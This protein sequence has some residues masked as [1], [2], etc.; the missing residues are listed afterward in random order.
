MS[1][2]TARTLGWTEMGLVPDSVI[3]AGIR[4][5]LDRKAEEIQS[6]DVEFS[7]NTLND[8]V[9]MMN[10]SPIAL[11]PELANEQH[12]EVPATFFGYCMGNYRKYSCCEWRDDTRTLTDAEGLALKTT[13]ERAGIENGMRILDMGCGWGSVSLYVAEHFPESQV[14]GVSNSSSQR[15]YILSQARE[16]GLDNLEIITADMNDF[17]APG[18]FD[19]IVSVEMF[20]HMRNYGELFRRISTWLNDGGRFFMHI[21]THRT[22]PYEFIDNGPTDWMSR[23]FFSGGIMPSVDLPLRFPKHLSVEQRWSWNGDHYAKT[24]R[25][26]LDTMDSNRNHIMPILRETYGDDEADRWWMRWRMFYMACEE[27]FAYDNGNEW[28]V[29]H[30][31]FSKEGSETS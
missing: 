7:S 18:T 12:Y 1:V 19:R 4:R 8:F 21:F 5:L 2:V 31:L 22:T 13:I 30:Y 14:V 3:R 16:R 6:G 15:D 25:A 10:D 27:L 23:H 26:W 20:E 29:S 11:V 24:C 28:F 9:D 17:E